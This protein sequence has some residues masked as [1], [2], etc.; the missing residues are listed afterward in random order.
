M[1]QPAGSDSF[2]IWKWKV[3][4]LCLLSSSSA[5]ELLREGE[6]QELRDDLL[7]HS[8]RLVLTPGLASAERQAVGAVLRQSAQLLPSTPK[9]PAQ[10]LPTTPPQPPPP[11]LQLP[12]PPSHL[13]E[14]TP[15][16][17]SS[18]QLLPSTPFWL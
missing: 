10:L 3:D 14:P 16:Q 5:S 6:L 9:L 17:L 2:R 7:A 4:D 12:P 18:A 11:P 13:R 15:P 8:R 1:A